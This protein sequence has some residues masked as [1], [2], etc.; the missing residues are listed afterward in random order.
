MTLCLLRNA[1]AL[2]KILYI[3]RTA[4]C[5]S[6]PILSDLDHNIIIQR[7]VLEAICNVSLKDVS[8]SQA[9]LPISAGGLGIRSFIML[10][11]SAFLA[12][13]AGSSLISQRILPA[14]LANVPCPF[15]NEAL[16]LWSHRTSYRFQCSKAK[17]LGYP[18]PP[19]PPP[20]PPHSGHCLRSPFLSRSDDASRGRLLASQRKES[21]AYIAQCSTSVIPWPEDGQPHAL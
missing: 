5:F 7:S 8:W 2:P 20:P 19:P 15:N 18:P 17:G 9:S 13:A 14:S 11:L 6:S 12:S 4:P 16:A 10:A 3:L 1:F 21:S